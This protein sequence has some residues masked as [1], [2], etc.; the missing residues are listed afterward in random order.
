V[1]KSI[2]R[3]ILFL[4]IVSVANADTR[5]RVVAS[6]SVES[7]V[8]LAY[9]HI[10]PSPAVIPGE[11]FVIGTSVGYGFFDLFDI[12][13]NLVLDVQSVFNVST[14]LGI[15]HNHDFAFA[16]YVSFET[17]SLIETD[18]FGNQTTV[19]STAWLPGGVFSYRIA[20]AL[21]GDT[22][23]TYVSRNPPIPKS[24]VQDP[25]TALIQGNTGNQEFTVGV[26]RTVALSMGV[27]YDF[28]YDIFGAGASIHVSGFQLG[29]HYYFNVGQGNFMPIFGFGFSTSF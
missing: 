25:R 3:I 28:T 17:Q 4:L 15:F 10:A 27:S 9:T 12:T 1:T 2:F 19:T 8:P 18:Q 6:E 22:A 7:D 14:K 20:P 16:P 5:K 11:T 23:F 21:T 26:A 13:S 24:T 29:G